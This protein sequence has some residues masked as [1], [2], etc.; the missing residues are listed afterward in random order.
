MDEQ[1]WLECT[2]P[3]PMVEFL[4]SKAS[5]R[6]SRLLACAYCRRAWGILR[7]IRSK[8]AN[9]VAERYADGQAGEEE[10]SLAMDIASAAQQTLWDEFRS[11]AFIDRQ[12][13]FKAT[14]ELEVACAVWRTCLPSQAY[15]N[16]EVVGLP[17]RQVAYAIG[18]RK[19]FASE[20][21]VQ[22][23]VLHD[24]FG[25]PFRPITINPIWLTL[26]VL[27]LA[28]SAYDERIMPSGELDPARLAVLSDALEEVGC[29]NNDILNHLRGPGPHVRGCWVL[30]L[31]LGKE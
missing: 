2:E 11:S 23:S 31:L 8:E 22:S 18:G 30:D 14:R 27:T 16:D 26:T 28:Q 29:D 15:A 19:G 5:E 25:N 4:G 9:E 1:E 7:D 24:I 20:A 17:P 21:A 13:E 6:K 12:E 10:R 3:T